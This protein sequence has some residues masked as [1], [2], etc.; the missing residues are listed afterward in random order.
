MPLTV[1]ELV[2][3]KFQGTKQ[4][5]VSYIASNAT[6]A[7]VDEIL[8]LLASTTKNS[9][10]HMKD[11]GMLSRFSL[12]LACDLH[13]RDDGKTLSIERFGLRILCALDS[14]DVRAQPGP[15]RRRNGPTILPAPHE[16]FPRRASTTSLLT[17]PGRLNQHAARRLSSSQRHEWSTSSQ[18]LHMGLGRV[19]PCAHVG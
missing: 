3:W 19:V 11:T 4:Y 9:S 18:A 17:G 2:S 14:R 7:R 1:T 16:K 5:S 6:K 8:S 13:P 15:Q 10:S 12:G